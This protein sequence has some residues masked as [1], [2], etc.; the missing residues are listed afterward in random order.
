MNT[1]T[2]RIA[3]PPDTQAILAQ[4]HQTIE[5][6]QRENRL[7]HEKVQY[8]LHL[9]FG[10]KAEQ[11]PAGQGQLFELPVPVADEPPPPSVNSEPPARRPGGR[12]KPPPEL[13]RVRVEHDLAETEKRCSCGADLVR[14]GEVVS[15]QYDIVPPRFQVLEHVRFQ[16]ACPG[17]RQGVT[18]APKAPDPLPQTQ[19]SPALLAWIGAG[20]FADGLPL[21]RQARI[22]EQRF[23]VPFSSTTLAAWTIATAERLFAPLLRRL[24]EALLASDYWHADETYFQVLDEPG[25]GAWQKSF[26]W[27]RLSATGPPVVRL[28]YHPSRSG[29]AADTLFAGFAGY[30]Q[31]DGYAGYNGVA[32]RDDVISLGCWTHARRK[33]DA[34][35]KAT[36]QHSPQ[37]ALAREALAFIRQLYAIEKAVKGQTFEA[38]RETRQVESRDV[39]DRLR[40]WMESHLDHAAQA[41]SAL[42]RAFTYLRNQ[43]PKLERF[44]EDGRLQLD[45]N[46]AERHIR[47]IAMGRKAWL[48]CQSPAGAH[49]TAAWYSVV[50][51]AKAN[52]WE[53]FHYLSWLFQEMP[54]YLQQ[55]LPL[56]PLLP[57]VARPDHIGG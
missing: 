23:G 1:A 30:L 55:N 20:K 40:A 33:F 7:L 5:A 10:R 14:L 46:R 4:L 49:A 44:L 19:A 50:E 45:N 29:A 18:L 3:E 8:L 22:L 53:P 54:R 37:A 34:V 38:I 56:D 6:L 36:G 11:P 57:W 2:H 9:R 21:H 24:E 35:I 47:P 43:W 41:G 17:C 51:T 32:G 13:P 48:F 31:T 25:K 12:R 52:G 26:F 39:L 28:D 27:I 42:G 16:Y 15:E